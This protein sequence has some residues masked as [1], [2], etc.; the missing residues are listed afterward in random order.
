MT[1]LATAP[2]APRDF[3]HRYN[4]FVARHLVAWELSFAALAVLFVALAFVPIPAGSET[5]ATVL[6]LEWSITGIFIA[7]VHEPALGG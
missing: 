7:G 4:A 1:E 6:A 3:R 2:G 5:E